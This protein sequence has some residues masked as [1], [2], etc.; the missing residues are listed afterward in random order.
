[1]KKFNEI[2]T[3]WTRKR[4]CLAQNT[5]VDY[6]C[7]IY[8]WHV[9][10]LSYGLEKKI[11]RRGRWKG[12]ESLV[13]YLAKKTIILLSENRSSKRIKTAGKAKNS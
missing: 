12:V 5:L 13:G 3:S 8:L 6:H 1:M 9:G 7:L 11:G 2:E 10:G 4:K